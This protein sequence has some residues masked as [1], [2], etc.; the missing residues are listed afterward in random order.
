MKAE[1]NKNNELI[2]T[3]KLNTPP[4]LSSSGKTY[5]VASSGG[6]K[7]TT[8]EVDGKCVSVSVNATVERDDEQEEGTPENPVV[9]KTAKEASAK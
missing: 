6:F 9:K 1:I 4:K 2:I 8:A 7:G 3:I 5:V